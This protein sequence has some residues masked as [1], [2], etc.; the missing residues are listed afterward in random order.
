MMIKRAVLMVACA[1]SV[2]ALADNHQP[3]GPALGEVY[4]C[5]LNA[6]VSLSNALEYART[7]FKDFADEH[8]FEHE[9][10]YLGSGCC[11]R[12]L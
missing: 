11:Q 8:K 2:S 5:Q 12:A 3:G 10:L 4:D 1:L 7:D 6:G 9:Y